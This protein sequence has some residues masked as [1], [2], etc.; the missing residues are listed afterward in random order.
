MISVR[1]VPNAK[2]NDALAA[3]PAKPGETNTAWLA[4]VGAKT[5]ILLVG[6]SSLSHFRLRVAQSHLRRDMLPSFWSLAGL[7]HD[8]VVDTVP[9]ECRAESSEVPQSN[10]IPNPGQMS[11]IS[12]PNT[13]ANPGGFG[14]PSCHS[15][16]GQGNVVSRGFANTL[17]A[18][19]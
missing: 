17:P 11:G 3:V 10:G 9:L 7:L 19:R 8:N 13:V 5:G 18:N 4:R 1:H 12:G 2:E 15:Y 14:H 6:G 16:S